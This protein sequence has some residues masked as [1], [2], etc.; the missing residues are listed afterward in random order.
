MISLVSNDFDE[1]GIELN[2]PLMNEAIK[3]KDK[4]I[5]I[6]Q[7]LHIKTYRTKLTLDLSQANLWRM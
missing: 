4:E 6:V 1:L 5:A 2:S 3:R 7:I